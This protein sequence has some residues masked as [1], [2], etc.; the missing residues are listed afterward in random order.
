V[1]I[2]INNK[3]SFVLIFVLVFVFIFVLIKKNKPQVLFFALAPRS[4]A[5]R[6]GKLFYKNQNGFYIP[7]N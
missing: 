3:S 2:H 4:A 7:F 5:S 6:G 1:H